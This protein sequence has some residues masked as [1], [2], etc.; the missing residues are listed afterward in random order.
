MRMLKNKRMGKPK[1]NQ[2]KPQ[3]VSEPSSVLQRAS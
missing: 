1:G 3:Y 2:R